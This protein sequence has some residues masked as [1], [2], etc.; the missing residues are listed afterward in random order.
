MGGGGGRPGGNNRQREL[1]FHTQ[2]SLSAYLGIASY[3][4]AVQSTSFSLRKRSA[5]FLLDQA[6]EGDGCGQLDHH[7]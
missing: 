6:F 2:Q 4:G 3:L 5:W 1:I 7:P